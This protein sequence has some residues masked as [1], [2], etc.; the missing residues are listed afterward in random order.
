MTGDLHNHPG[1]NPGILSIAYLG[2]VSYFS[3]ILLH[4]SIV[5][6]KHENYSR[7]SYRNRCEIL[8]ANG[9]IALSIPIKKGDEHKTPVKDVRIEYDKKWQH[10]HWKSIESAYRSSPFYEFYADYLEPFYSMRENY[11]F[12]FNYKLL[13][14]ILEMIELEV[15]ISVSEEYV[16]A[17]D[18]PGS[19]Y[20]DIIHPK[21]RDLA[22]PMF[23]ALEYNQVFGERHGFQPDLSILDLVFNE[24]P[25]SLEVLKKCIKY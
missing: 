1:K 15:R 2:P 10:L 14:T 7:Q 24:G 4:G 18:F 16:P 9:S 13:L 11:L 6:E 3:K 22:D 5:I 20:R 25:N 19:D 17:R 12:D 8:G 23:R 21:K